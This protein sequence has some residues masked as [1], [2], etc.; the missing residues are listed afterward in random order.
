MKMNRTYYNSQGSYIT[1]KNISNVCRVCLEEYDHMISIHNNKNDLQKSVLEMINI[2][3]VTKLEEHNLFPELVCKMCEGEIVRA[4]KLRLKFNKSQSFLNKYI[5]KLETNLLKKDEIII[6]NTLTDENREHCAVDQDVVEDC[7]DENHEETIKEL[8]EY[9]NSLQIF[10]TNVEKSDLYKKSSSCV[11]KKVLCTTCNVKFP[12]NNYKLHVKKNHSKI[13]KCNLCDKTFANNF[14]LQR[15]I[16]THTNQTPFVCNLCGLRFSR[17]DNLKKH[18]LFHSLGNNSCTLCGQQFQNLTALR[19]HVEERSNCHTTKFR[20]SLSCDV[21]FKKFSLISSLNTHKLL[22]TDKSVIC[23]HCSNPY[24]NKKKL[25]IHIQSVHQKSD[26]KQFLCNFCAKQYV[27][28]AAL[29]AHVARHQGF[30]KKYACNICH[31]NF[32]QY[33]SLS[34]HAIIH[35]DKKPFICHVCSAAF[36]KSSNLDRHLRTHSDFRPHQ[37]N[38]CDKSFR[39]KQSLTIHIRTH[40]GEKPF[41]CLECGKYFSDKSTLIKHAKLHIKLQTVDN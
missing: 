41:P 22:H 3:M 10:S 30:E 16:F 6:I 18:L 24:A 25:Q 26:V 32:A 4:T 36:N 23:G 17:Q 31:K 19:R 40:T 5:A 29:D 35:T 27:S 8:N 39:Y 2:S 33:S 9:K 1:I 14:N 15:H 7:A 38:L 34:L 11:R 20:R 12:V 37:C 28:K 13:F 21:C